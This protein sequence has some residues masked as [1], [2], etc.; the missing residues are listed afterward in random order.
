[1][2][3]TELNPYLIAVHS[4]TNSGGAWTVDLEEM[5]ISPHDPI[6]MLNSGLLGDWYSVEKTARSLQRFY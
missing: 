6:T 5:M 4:L 3:R 2:K 1:L